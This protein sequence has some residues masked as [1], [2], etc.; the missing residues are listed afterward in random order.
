MPNQTAPEVLPKSVHHI[1]EICHPFSP[2][3]IPQICLCRL[4]LCVV[5]FPETGHTTPLRVSQR[6]AEMQ[7]LLSITTCLPP[8]QKKVQRMRSKQMKEGT[9]SWDLDCGEAT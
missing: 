8:V 9:L 3:T 5:S 4:R 1:N 7:T 6:M 2:G